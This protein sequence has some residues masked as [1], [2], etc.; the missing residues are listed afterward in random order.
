MLRGQV[1]FD[2]AYNWCNPM[3]NML[4]LP[5]EELF[6][7]EHLGKIA[8]SYFRKAPWIE[9]EGMGYMTPQYPSKTFTSFSHTMGDIINAVAQNDLKVM[10][11]NE[12]DYDIGMS[13]VYNGR[14]IL[15]S[16]VLV[17]KKA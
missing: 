3:L 5:W 6:D 2:F 4:A 13:E 12:Y 7:P 10:Q 9:N 11:L 15:L 1:R 8:Y 17:A 14:G 16:F